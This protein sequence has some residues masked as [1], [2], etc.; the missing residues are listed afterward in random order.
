[1]SKVQRA[2]DQTVLGHDMYLLMQS[3]NGQQWRHALHELKE[4][5]PAVAGYISTA[6]KTVEMN[7]SAH[8]CSP[9]GIRTTQQFL[10]HALVLVAVAVRDGQQRL[11][12]DWLPDDGMSSADAETKS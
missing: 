8:D 1:M 10:Q 6:A 12:D 3:L 2:S 7:L 9:E 4:T 5:E 11:M